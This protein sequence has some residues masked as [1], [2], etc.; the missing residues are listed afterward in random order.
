LRA[1]DAAAH[2]LARG[3]A[4]LRNLRG[5]ARARLARENDDLMRLD[6]HDDILRPRADRQLGRKI[7]AKAKRSLGRRRHGVLSEAI[8]L[9]HECTRI[10]TNG[11]YFVMPYPIQPPNGE[12]GTFPAILVH[13]PDIHVPSYSHI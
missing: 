4:H 7:E 11:T 6:G 3:Q 1:G 5:F 9:S 12:R 13:S 10:D 8:Q 2:S